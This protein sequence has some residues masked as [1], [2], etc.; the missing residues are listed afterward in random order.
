MF[1]HIFRYFYHLLCA[2]TVFGF[3]A[4]S[5]LDYETQ[6]VNPVHEGQF[7]S[8]YNF[9]TNQ[10][11]TVNGLRYETKTQNGVTESG[12]R[13]RYKKQEYI[14]FYLGNVKLGD[15]VR[16]EKYISPVNLVP[17][18]ISVENQRVTN[19]T[20]LLL[21]IG[22]VS[23]N[24]INIPGSV[25]S[26]IE[27]E[28]KI[29]TNDDSANEYEINFED[30]GTDE[31]KAFTEYAN[32][33]IETLN[34]NSGSS[35][36]SLVNADEAQGSLQKGLIQVEQE[37]QNDQDNQ[38]NNDSDP[39][40]YSITTHFIN[41]P[42]AAYFDRPEEVFINGDPIIPDSDGG[43]RENIVLKNN[44][45]N[46]FSITATRYNVPIGE[47]QYF[48]NHSPIEYTPGHQI[49][50][51]YSVDATTSETIVIDLEATKQNGK[52]G[53]VVGYIPNVNIVGC[54]NDNQFLIDDTGQVYLS[55]THQAVG[56]PLPFSLTGDHRFFPLF[57][58]D[59]HYCYAGTIKIDFEV[60]KAIYVDQE[61]VEGKWIYPYFPVYVDSRYATITEDERYLFQTHSPIKTKPDPSNASKVLYE[62]SVKVDLHTDEK[63]ETIYIQEDEL[64]ARN[65]LADMIVTPDGHRG[66]L[67]TF[68]SYYSSLDIID[69]VSK[70]VIKG[71][72]GLSDHPGNS[73]FIANHSQVLFGAAGNSWY[74]G[75]SLT[76]VDTD[77]E[78]ITQM[79]QFNVAILQYGHE[80]CGLYGK[81]CGQYGAYAVARDRDGL[82]Y[83]SSRY[84]RDLGSQNEINNCSPGRRGIDQLEI[85]DGGS[86]KYIQTYFLNAL[87]QK[88]MHFIK[89]K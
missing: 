53:V 57:S 4:C 35:R 60:W 64:V 7:I 25:I 12:G 44:Q 24:M 77:G 71:I 1:K 13:F 80:D 28:A 18:A 38:N 61:I 89:G 50:Y 74:G 81:S 41:Y 6:K 48:I 69:L 42:L 83:I 70:T 20:R 22:T 51:S 86:F 58:P 49:L 54:S 23:A 16:A 75:G 11:Q 84:T 45:S 5:D 56:E 66:F 19:I 32:S 85:L 39:G 43:F 76:I 10:K 14:T 82:L 88:T 3:S 34:E 62:I 47:K 59:D 68:S 15:S 17:N 65:T 67:T 9:E 72:Q 37:S 55:S 21:S 2:F 31:A 79:N 87:D 52:N 63:I 29:E 27:A 33:I 46:T 30:Q 73:I 78:L 36:Y 8:G 40:S 26:V